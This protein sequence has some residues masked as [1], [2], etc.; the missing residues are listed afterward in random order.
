MKS[1]LTNHSLTAPV[2]HGKLDFETWQQIFYAEYDGERAKRIL[3]KVTGLWAEW[4]RLTA[5]AS[6]FFLQ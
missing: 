1:F 2:T 3:V 4:G 5:V 6:P